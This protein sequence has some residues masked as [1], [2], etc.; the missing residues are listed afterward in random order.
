MIA[1]GHQLLLCCV[2]SSL[3]LPASCSL[4][5]KRRSQVSTLPVRTYVVD[6]PV[7]L[8]HGVAAFAVY[9]EV[10]PFVR[11]QKQPSPPSVQLCEFDTLGSHSWPPTTVCWFPPTFPQLMPTNNVAAFEGKAHSAKRTEVA[12]V[13]DISK[14]LKGLPGPKGP[15]ECTQIG[16]L[17]C[18]CTCS[19]VI[20][21][22]PLPLPSFCLHSLHEVSMP[23]INQP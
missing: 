5:H 18:L 10:A 21:R 14:S 11:L 9:Q 3:L 13:F 1:I 23:C 2:F 19:D 4:I 6:S 12:P 8:Q 17:P 22:L 20:G 16:N 15:L 7:E